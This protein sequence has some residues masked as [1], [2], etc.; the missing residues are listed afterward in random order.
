MYK[1]QICGTKIPGYSI[2]NN[3]KMKEKIVTT[4]YD[5]IKDGARDIVTSLEGMVKTDFE[6]TKQML[7]AP[8]LK[9]TDSGYEREV[10]SLE[11]QYDK[12]YDR[13]IY[14]KDNFEDNWARTYSLIFDRFCSREM[15]IALKESKEYL[16]LIKGD[17][18]ALIEAAEKLSLQPVTTVKAEIQLIETLASLIN[19]RQV[20]TE[21]LD[22][23]GERFKSLMQV[24]DK[25]LGKE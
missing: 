16:T 1:Y 7:G 13:W 5:V 2:P 22:T 11:I 24:L 14:K 12:D 15:Q 19:C 6:K 10:K 18:V 8:E 9:Q 25:M 17:P 20:D 21:T 3:K 4:I 23:Y